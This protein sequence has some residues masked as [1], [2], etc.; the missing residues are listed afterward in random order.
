VPN[1]ASGRYEL[2]ER[3][4]LL[5]PLLAELYRTGEALLDH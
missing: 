3:G 5:R 4:Q 2:T 1:G